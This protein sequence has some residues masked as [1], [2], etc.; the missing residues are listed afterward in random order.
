MINTFFIGDTHFGHANIIGFCRPQFNNLDEMHEHIVTRW[1]SV[2]RPKDKVM[3]MGDFCMN[4]KYIAEFAPQL[5][6]VKHIVLGNHDQKDMQLYQKYFQNVF[7][8]T[9]Y[10]GCVLTH[11]PIHESQFYR[12]KLNIHGHMHEKSIDDPRYFNVSCEQ[13]NYTPIEWEEI[14]E[15][16]KEYFLP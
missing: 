16:R 6:G 13:I 5:N 14:K 2:V 10:K 8:C 4:K 11:I 1:N 9:G 7:G 12:W 15:Q 3:F